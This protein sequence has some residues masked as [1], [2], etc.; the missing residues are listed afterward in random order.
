M[1]T[2]PGTF[3]VRDSSD[4]RFLFSLSVQTD[5]GPTSVRIHYVNGH[6]RLDAEPRLAPAMPVFVCV[7]SLIE[8][9]VRF[10]DSRRNESSKGQVWIDC[11]GQMYSNIL[12]VKP[13]YQK[14]RFPSLQH[15]ARLSINRLAQNGC[16]VPT[17]GLP[18]TLQKYL[19]DYPF[20][21]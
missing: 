8:H 6:F 11:A 18:V 19:V 3:L 7:V 10:T 17:Y 4:P 20:F 16:Y 5:R 13:L 2:S 14:E 1:P 15:L 9:Y 21:Q 12:L